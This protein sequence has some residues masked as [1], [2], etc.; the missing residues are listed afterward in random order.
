MKNA[1]LKLTMSPRNKEYEV[2]SGFADECDITQLSQ[3]FNKTEVM[4]QLDTIVSEAKSTIQSKD[5]SDKEN[6]K[7]FIN[8]KNVHDLFDKLETTIC[9]L[10][11]SNQHKSEQKERKEF[12]KDIK[13]LK[14]IVQ[15]VISVKS[16]HDEHLLNEAEIDSLFNITPL[17]SSDHNLKE[18]LLEREFKT[19]DFK[20]QLADIE[21]F[22]RKGNFYDLPDKVKTLIKL[23]RGIDKLYGMLIF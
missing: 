4:N 22:K 3:F 2:S 11:H 17:E 5:D 7:S 16:D 18:S 21:S 14:T 19:S 15:K 8:K 1:K 10:G 6:D 23:Y 13:L 9:E 12:S 20:T